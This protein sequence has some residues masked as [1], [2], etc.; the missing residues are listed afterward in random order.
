MVEKFGKKGFVIVGVTS[1]AKAPTETYLEET[2]WKATVALE[3][4][5]GTMR[6]YGFTGYPSS[7][8]VGPTGKVVWTGHPSGLSERVIEENLAG[9]RLGGPNGLALDIELPRK[10]R[11]IAKKLSKGT[12][13]PAYLDL[14]KAL[15]RLGQDADDLEEAA[16]LRD[17]IQQVDALAQEQLD[18]A[19]KA[20]DEGRYF[21]A[22]STWKLVDKHLA[23]HAAGEAAATRLSE[24]A[25]RAE[26]VDE[27]EAGER[28]AR[29]LAEAAEEKVDKAIK[30]L[31]AVASG[32]LKETREAERAVRLIEEM[33]GEK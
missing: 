6:A 30:T 17:A 19:S 12:L 7:T 31:K 27:I 16:V 25:A 28:I 32:S 10:H 33:S 4:S 15:D 1:E 2:G 11:A 26:L 24:L 21:D 5:G 20:F 8:L 9:V 29:A 22:Q 3:G 23:K 14:Q 18:L 13:G